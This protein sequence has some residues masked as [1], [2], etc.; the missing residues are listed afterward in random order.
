MKI[1]LSVK[2]GKLKLKNPVMVAS[3]TFGD[4]YAEL[5]D[6]GSLGAIVAKTIT[7]KPRI[8]NPPPR[9]VETASGM[10]NAIGL[11][12][13]G[14]EYFIKEKL[15]ALSR[16]KVPVIASISGDNAKEFA[17]LAKELTATKKIGAIELN[18][19][20]PNISR[21]S[22]G[23]GIIAQDAKA[24]Y[25][26]VKAV[27]KATGLTI[28]AK[29]SPNITDIKVIARAAESAGANAISLVNTFLG[30]AV[31]TETKK[32]ILGNIT[33]GLSGPAI[34]PLALKMVW[35]TYNAVKIPIIGMGGITN[36]KDAI[37]FM[38]CGAAAVQVGTAN[39]INPNTAVEVVS[40]I[41]GY[42][43][44]NKIK[45]IKELTGSLNTGKTV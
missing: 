26:V 27:R 17:V 39:F 4:E 28:I 8:G 22:S 41:K 32:P 33:G 45:N 13:K 30:M 34:K 19:S 20:C 29:L 2:I 44:K 24:V 1:D 42:L 23:T 37:E 25:S 16:Y 14:L 38:L 9:V 15:P 21:H 35:E 40:G 5:T 10:L 7:L 36:Y 31:D 6:I 43:I 11:E 3:G 12:N 18:L